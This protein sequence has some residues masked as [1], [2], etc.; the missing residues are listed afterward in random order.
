MNKIPLA[1]ERA[2]AGDLCTISGWNLNSW[3]GPRTTYFLR[4]NK[5]QV[6]DGEKCKTFTKTIASLFCAADLRNNESCNVRNIESHR[7]DSNVR[8]IIN[9]RVI[10]E[11]L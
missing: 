6:F 5:L 3:D 1:T 2:K 11:V 8:S 9:F 4:Y 7:R 10:Q